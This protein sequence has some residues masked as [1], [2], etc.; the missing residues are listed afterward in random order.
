[1]A[2]RAEQADEPQRR[3]DG[4]AVGLGAALAGGVLA[5]G[6]ANLARAASVAPIA[7]G[8]AWAAGAA[9]AL[10]GGGMVRALPP[11]RR[12]GGAAALLA[13]GVAAAALG[14]ALAGAPAAVAIAIGLLALGGA[15][16]AAMAPA[17]A[18]ARTHAAIAVGALAAAACANA[19][20][21]GEETPLGAGVVAALLAAAACAR[22]RGCTAGPRPT[23]RQ[24][25]VVAG[26]ASALVAGAAWLGPWFDGLGVL[27]AAFASAAFACATA[28][29]AAARPLP[30]V[31]ALACALAVAHVGRPPAPMLPGERVL[32]AAGPDTA[33]FVRSRHE[34]QWRVGTAVREA[35]GPERAAHSVAATIVRAATRAG[36]RVLVLGGSGR[37]AQACAAG[38]DRVVDVVDDRPHAAVVR[39]AFAGDGPV[40]PLASDLPA[41]RALGVAAALGALPAGSRQAIV[42]GVLPTPGAAHLH[43]DVQ[44]ELARVAAGGL[45]LQPIAGDLDDVAATAQL[46]AAAA[47]V[48]P[49]LAIVAVGDDAVLVGAATAWPWREVADWRAWPAEARWLAHAAHLGDAA[50][51]DAACLGVVDAAALPRALASAPSTAGGMLAAVAV[52][53]PPATPRADSLFAAWTAQQAAL[54]AARRRLAGLPDDADGRAEA[55]ALA[56]R[57][58]PIGAP[59]AELQVAL[60]AS[61]RDGVAFATPMAAARA[62]AALD[63][64]WRRAAPAVLAWLPAA[65]DEVGALEDLAALPPPA[66]LVEVA[67]GDDARAVGLRVRF[68][69]ACAAAFVAALVSGPLPPP[70]LQ[71]LRQLAD[72]FV[73]RE[74][75]AAL[76]PA[77][78]LRELLGAWRGGLP[79]PPELVALAHGSGDDRRALAVALTGRREPTCAL[80]L[81]ELL[82]ADEADVR[83][84]AAVA[85]EHQF[86]GRVA[87][88]PSG[89]LSERRAAAA[90]VRSLHNRAP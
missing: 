68:P 18:P 5:L 43:V 70:A 19:S 3:A 6:A 66:R 67:A 4:L 14:Q 17:S 40:A 13:A 33:V 36:D 37:Q 31:L 75:A 48:F 58:L 15:A 88:D 34:R 85:L 51:L 21:P 81:A 22:V 16:A 65:G 35:V 1:M 10:V 50:D 42:V 26:T 57:F 30:G 27:V 73:L 45:V 23:W 41:G 56:A 86:P 28:A 83:G 77:G 84:I 38:G 29:A 72:P 61:G 11:A 82:L 44:R 20:H 12:S 32:A 76:A 8:L 90:R 69:S 2:P 89:P 54:A 39:A 71:A 64:C 47:A 80:A 79:M 62:A 9:A 87:Y 24:G 53:R 60:A 55:S 7:P 59:C 74:A 25:A 63:P 78:R 49:W 52:A 46:C